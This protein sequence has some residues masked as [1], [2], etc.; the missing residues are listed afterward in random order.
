MFVFVSCML[1]PGYVYYL[2]MALSSPGEVKND[3][4]EDNTSR[5]AK[6]E[7]DEAYTCLPPR[8]ATLCKIS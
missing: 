7:S 6:R 2:A 3:A 1:A 4:R 8:D 5:N